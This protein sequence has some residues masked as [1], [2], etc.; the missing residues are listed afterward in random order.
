MM[1][2]IKKVKNPKRK[3]KNKRCLEKYSKFKK[4]TKY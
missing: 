4:L 2:K 1:K 3:I